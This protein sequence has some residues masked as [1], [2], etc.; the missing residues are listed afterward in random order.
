MN[1]AFNQALIEQLLPLA[2]SGDFSDVFNSATQEMSSNQRFLLKMEINRL[3]KPCQRIIDL[4]GKVD[5]ECQ[6][7]EHNGLTHFLDE[8]AVNEFK[9]QL[10]RF[11]GTYTMGVYEALQQTENN[12]RV[13]QQ[14]N[15]DP[16]EAAKQRPKQYQARA[17]KLGQFISRNEERMHLAA[18]LKLAGSDG[19]EFEAMSSNMS[20]SGIKVKVDKDR[21]FEVG[22]RLI[23]YFTG[24]EKEFANKVLGA[25][26]EYQ[27]VGIN[28]SDK[29]QSLRMI[30]VNP[31]AEF[32]TFF[33][34]YLRSYKGRYRVDVDSVSSAVVTKGYQQYLMPR[35]HGIPVY[36]DKGEPSTL[37]FAL[38]TP[39]NQELLA[40]WRDE[41][42]HSHLS[43]LFHKPRML[44][45]QSQIEGETLIFCF[46]H[47]ARERL[48]FYTAT[49]EELEEHPQLRELFIGFGSRKPS[50]RVMKY[51][52]QHI[53][54]APHVSASSLS[55][56]M[57]A[58]DLERINT[59][60]ENLRTVGLLSDVT[61]Q[62]AGELY[63]DNYPVKLNPNQLAIFNQSK[64]VSP[65]FEV[66]AYK[67]LQLR[68]E[69]RYMYR[70]LVEVE[71]KHGEKLVAWC[72]DFSVHGMQIE[73]EGDI[74]VAKGDTL[75]LSL[76]QF[77]KLVKSYNL[78]LLPYRVVN[79]NRQGNVFNLQA[80][81]I[82]H[83]LHDGM[84]FFEQLIA[85]NLDKL[86]QVPE[87]PSMNGLS[88]TLRQLF[89]EPL[90]C[91][92][93]YIEKRPGRFDI[94]CLGYGSHPHSFDSFTGVGDGEHVAELSD[95]FN[96][97]ELHSKLLDT[98]R[99]LDAEHAPEVIEL[100]ALVNN[101]T[102]RLI[103]LRDVA[104]LEE[105][106]RLAE[107]VKFASGKGRV[108]SFSLHIS[109]VGR[110]DTEF[111]QR[112]LDYIS[113]YAIHKAKQLEDE[114]WS[115][116]GVAVVTDTTAELMHRLKMPEFMQLQSA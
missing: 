2:N 11:A 1:A 111:I 26:T 3:A 7:F 86:N 65:S 57:G 55:R 31:D 88:E 43:Q 29:D 66:V 37:R 24:L 103:S 28:H 30:V 17:V 84:R 35:L 69:D 46:T 106:G 73:V 49:R 115:V 105:S 60:V 13:M 34:T 82:E 114:L 40:Y 79:H 116:V 107:Y 109:R 10:S 38:S 104:E 48:F 12:F 64:M 33:E 61:A 78:K 14:R 113:H 44:R 4:R 39:N 89:C 6:A 92:A 80:A 87:R 32:K 76:P 53:D 42:N 70:S 36:F 27:I 112:E 15:I 8:I 95:L 67:Y 77:Q 100:L 102:R 56:K 108:L 93:L 72:R 74:T 101:N 90:F 97:G 91:R 23:V 52:W 94:S 9:A 63:H 19:E 110:P 22:Q 75:Y 99:N 41:S 21:Q 71:T 59:A 5:G 20:V 83:Q 98:V 51:Q 16:Q 45:Y 18:P 68:R 50:W 96:Q 62:F 54:E 47:T 58:V 85:N 81:V 25:G